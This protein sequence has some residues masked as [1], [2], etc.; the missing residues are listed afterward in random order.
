M[1]SIFGLLAVGGAIIAKYIDDSSTTEA[2]NNK[3]KKADAINRELEI[4]IEEASDLN[5]HFRDHN[6][7]CSLLLSVDDG[8]TY[9]YGYQWRKIFESSEYVPAVYSELN[10]IWGVAFQL[11]C[12]KN[13]KIGLNQKN[14]Q[15]TGNQELCAIKVKACEMIEKYI[16]DT[17]QDLELV[18]VPGWRVDS[19]REALSYHDEICNGK[20]WWKHNLPP[21][22]KEQNLLVRKLW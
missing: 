13:G 3:R 10:T 11:V 1:W 17:N 21:M 8:L 15:L 12:A 16:R 7:R 18:F 22:K 2:F 20:L 6:S 5:K 4:T 14:Y 9:I 19:S